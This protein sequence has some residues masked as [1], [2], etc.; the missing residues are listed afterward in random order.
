MKNKFSKETHINTRK[1]DNS[2]L[3]VS[4]F[5]RKTVLRKLIYKFQL[6]VMLSVRSMNA[7]CL[8]Y[9]NS[10]FHHYDNNNILD[11]NAFRVKIQS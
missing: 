6:R 10:L 4:L 7:E 9:E 8:L 3:E 2:G 11:S 5:S 1:S